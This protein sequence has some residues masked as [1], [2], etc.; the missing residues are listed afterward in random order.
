MIREINGSDFVDLV[1][2]YYE[3][4]SEKSQKIIPLK[5]VYIPTAKE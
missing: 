4:L 2:K 3:Q 1:L 5:K